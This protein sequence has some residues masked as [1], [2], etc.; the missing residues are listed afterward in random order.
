MSAILP[1]CITETKM[2]RRFLDPR[3]SRLATSLAVALAGLLVTSQTAYAC[4]STCESTYG[5]LIPVSDTEVWELTGCDQ[6]Y[7]SGGGITTKC[8][9]KVHRFSPE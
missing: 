4:I 2:I 1:G 7:N 3:R 8:Y 5:P 9:Y 6:Y